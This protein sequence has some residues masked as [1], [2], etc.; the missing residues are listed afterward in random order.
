V[1]T[2]AIKPPQ[3]VL[4]WD[5]ANRHLNFPPASDQVLVE[6]M[7]AAATALLD[8]PNGALGRAIG[9]QQLEARFDSF[10]DA[11]LR[12]NFPPVISIA[13]VAYLDATGATITADPASYRL[14]DRELLPLY[15]ASWPDA[16]TDREAVRVRYWAG[17][18]SDP[19]KAQPPLA[20]PA[21]IRSAILLMVADLYENRGTTRDARASGAVAVPMS[22]TV[23]ALL[24]ACQLY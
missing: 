22:P 9:P 20:L 16:L 21:A 2:V 12:L 14:V 19:T 4:G 11:P 3:P 7:I 6:G 17:Y 13:S 18:T 8:G 23:N 5:D 15:G 1:R 10:V 24:A